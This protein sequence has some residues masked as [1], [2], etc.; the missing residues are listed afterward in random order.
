MATEHQIHEIDNL[1]NNIILFME[2]K[3]YSMRELSIYSGLAPNY[4]CSLKNKRIK[5]PSIKALS[6]IADELEVDPYMLFL[7]HEYLKPHTRERLRSMKGLSME[8]VQQILDNLDSCKKV[9]AL[10]F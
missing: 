9:K 4:I 7:P 2:D 10:K 5:Q 8:Q 1:C 6:D 3:G